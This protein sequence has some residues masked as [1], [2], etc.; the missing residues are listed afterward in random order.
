MNQLSLS[1]L[2]I[3]SL[4]SAHGD[5]GCYHFYISYCDIFGMRRMYTGG[6]KLIQLQVHKHSLLVSKLV[7][8]SDLFNT[9][10]QVVADVANM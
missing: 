4:V 9:T 2:A 3:A 7:N 10:W 1:D 5:P 6:G 8:R